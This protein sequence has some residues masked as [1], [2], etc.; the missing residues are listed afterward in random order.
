MPQGLGR[1]EDCRCLLGRPHRRGQ[2]A[3]QVMAGQTVVHQL[4]R[5][6]LS[7][8]GKQAGVGGVQPYLLA[9]QQ[10]A[11]DRLLQQRMAKRIGATGPVRYKDA[12]TD[13]LAQTLLKFRLG[14][15][16][17]L[18]EQAVDYPAAG[19][20]PDPQHLLGWLGEGFDPSQ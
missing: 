17:H 9:R 7:L 11:V 2:G 14:P 5:D 15:P 19:Y 1:G 18:G 4:G 20:R 6:A 16:G 13:R 12:G 3:D 8:A 10:V